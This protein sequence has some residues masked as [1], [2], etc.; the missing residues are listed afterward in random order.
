[1]S[2]TGDGM[3]PAD[4]LVLFGATGDLAHKKIF[5]ALYRMARRGVLDVPVIGLNCATGPAEMHEH[6]RHLSQHS[7]VPV[8]VLPNMGL[9]SVVD[10][11]MH[12][13][14]TP[15]QFVELLLAVRNWRLFAIFLKN[16]A[17][18]LEPGTPSWPE[19]RAPAQ[20][21]TRRRAAAKKVFPAS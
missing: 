18:P 13:D 19:G 21:R 4:A 6:I 2:D 12:Y 20:R 3:V 7:T 16:V 1:M 15:E 17:V 5:P 10:G 9:P 8:S 14:L 11:K